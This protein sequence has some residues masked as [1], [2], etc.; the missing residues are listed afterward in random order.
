MVES[1]FGRRGPRPIAL[2]R[3]V[4]AVKGKGQKRGKTH[5]EFD[6][7]VLHRF[8]VEANRWDGG[9]DFADL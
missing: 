8:D 6:V 2:I 9:D 7:L 5:L 4:K 3:D 1:R